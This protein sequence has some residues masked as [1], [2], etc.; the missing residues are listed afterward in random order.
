MSKNCLIGDIGGGLFLSD[1][2]L[3][4]D[5]EPIK[6][7]EEIEEYWWMGSGGD[8]CDDN[9]DNGRIDN[10]RWKQGNVFNDQKSCQAMIDI[11][12]KRDI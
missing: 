9:W 5:F 4:R 8:V 3:E 2:E 12:N 10:F 7:P 11:I 1:N 6:K